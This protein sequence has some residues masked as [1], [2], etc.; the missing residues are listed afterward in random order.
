MQRLASKPLLSLSF[1]NVVER[2]FILDLAEEEASI[3]EVEI[4]APP[5]P[6]AARRWP[7]V[8][9]AAIVAW[10][11]LIVVAGISRLP[12]AAPV[13]SAPSATAPAPEPRVEIAVAPPPPA[14][15]VAPPVVEVKRAAKTPA[16][17]AKPVVKAAAP[18]TSSLDEPGF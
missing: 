9:I 8:K 15:V 11:A 7:V 18:Q 16:K 17:V 13:Q 12:S 1:E 2:P 14:V 4:E 5:S 6:P 10:S 3:P